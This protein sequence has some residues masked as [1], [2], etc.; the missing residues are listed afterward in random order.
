LQLLAA[1]VLGAIVLKIAAATQEN[2]AERNIRTGF[3]FLQNRAGFAIGETLFAYGPTDSFGRALLAGLA[4]TLSISAAAIAIST[5]LGLLIGFARL[6]K[7]VLVRAVTGA[8]VEV[9]RNLPLLLQLFVWYSLLLYG[10]PPVAS[11]S[12]GATGAFLTNRGLFLPTLGWLAPVLAVGSAAAVL[13]SRKLAGPGRVA[14]LAAAV[15]AASG[16]AAAALAGYEPARV[17]V[18][19][20][21]GGLQLSVEFAALV[22]GL[23]VYTSAYLAEIVRGGLSTVARGQGE[24]ADALGLDAGQRLRHVVLPQALRIILPPM[25]SWHLNTVKN[26]SL[27]VAIGYPEVVSVIDTIVSQTG[28]AVEGVVLIVLTFLSTSLVLSLAMNLY[29]RRNAG[30]EPAAGPAARTAVVAKS[31]PGVWRSQLFGDPKQS[32]LTLTVGVLVAL[33]LWRILDWAVVN[34]V[35]LGTAA[36]CRAAQGAC[37]PF[38]TENARFILLG[39]YPEAEQWRPALVV[40]LFAAALGAS[41]FRRLWRTA[42][43]ALWAAALV[44]SPFLM[45]GGPFGLAPVPSDKWSGLPVTLLLAGYA[46]AGAFP[47]A[48]LLALARRS[49]R[50]VFRLV[51]T[52]FVEVVRG[53][54]LLGVLFIAAV[55][56]PLFVPEEMTVNAFLRVQIALVLFTAAYMAEAVRGGLLSLNKG[57]TEAA[58]ALGLSRPD[59]LRTVILPQALTAS[60]PSLVSI[61]ISEVKNTTLVL[62][63]GVFDLLQM[64]RLAYVPLEWRPFYVEAY[65]FVGVVYFALCFS[66]SRIAAK[67][68]R[69]Q[70]VPDPET[71]NHA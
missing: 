28:Q 67:I 37:W 10:A 70:G 30:W 23:S 49:R 5:V 1:L 45:A 58:R 63:V 17:G 51:A 50:P 46:V 33:A 31:G 4:N 25:T 12:D 2:L 34:A 62:I 9:V 29:A 48:I 53:V 66:L 35:F 7:N 60:L 22:L 47:L 68:E 61:A 16:S 18:Y 8:Y 15:A 55:L 56:F 52:A 64:A 3:D 41:F 27:A 32:L 24:A 26:S 20:I 36:D 42:V 57:Q 13:L 21:E 69:V 6:S 19:Q 11:L 43:P 39:S 65:L 44:A 59:A 38:V 54:P 14:V 71:T 40:A